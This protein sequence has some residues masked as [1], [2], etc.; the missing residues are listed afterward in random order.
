MSLRARREPRRCIDL[1]HVPDDLRLGRPGAHGAT[2]RLRSRSAAAGA[3]SFRWSS[4][5]KARSDRPLRRSL[6]GERARAGRRRAARRRRPLRRQGGRELGDAGSSGAVVRGGGHG[7]VVVGAT[8]MPSPRSSPQD[9]AAVHRCR[10]GIA[11]P[12]TAP[13]LRPIGAKCA[14]FGET[15][16]FGA[17][18]D[19][20]PSPNRGF[21]PDPYL[22]QHHADPKGR[23]ARSRALSRDL[24]ANSTGRGIRGA[25]HH[26]GRRG[27]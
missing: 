6:V 24:P 5:A 14:P 12:P 17:H 19:S 15:P 9:R 7:R 20:L 11:N 26:P 13:P 10:L 1:A 22:L 27:H 3:P 25:R 23:V 8:S 21:R 4:E 18:K 2:S 16:A